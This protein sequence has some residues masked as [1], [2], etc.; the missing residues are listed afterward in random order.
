VVK[1]KRYAFHM[2]AGMPTIEGLLVKRTRHAFIL[3]KAQILEAA[4]RTHDLGGHVEVLREN[5][6]CLQELE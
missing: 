4:D 2:K 6:Y 3:I 5:V 1:T